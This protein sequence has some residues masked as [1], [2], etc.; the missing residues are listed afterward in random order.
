MSNGVMWITGRDL[1][2]HSDCCA[3]S[4]TCTTNLSTPQYAAIMAAH[5]QIQTDSQNALMGVIVAENRV[6]FD[7]TVN[8]TLAIDSDKGDHAALCDRPDWPW[9]LPTIPTLLSLKSVPD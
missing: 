5:E 6:N 1:F 7:M 2:T 4:N 8:S 9:A 3:P